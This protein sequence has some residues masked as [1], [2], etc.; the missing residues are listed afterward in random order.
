MTPAEIP[1]LSASELAAAIRSGAVSPAAAVDAYLDRIAAVGDRLNAYITVCADEAR[2]DAKLLAEEADAGN[3]RGP[4][5]GVPRGYQGPD[6]YRRRP[7]HRR[8][9]NPRRL[10]ARRPTPPWPPNSKPPAPS[11]SARPT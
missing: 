6:T 4:L 8:L 5:H 1:F 3:F 2:A 10:R 11:S 9:Q 7:H